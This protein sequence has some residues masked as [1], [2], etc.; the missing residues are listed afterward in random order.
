MEY[1]VYINQFIGFNQLRSTAYAVWQHMRSSHEPTADRVRSPS[2]SLVCGQ[3]EIMML[4]VMG[5]KIAMGNVRSANSYS[6]HLRN[7]QIET[8]LQSRL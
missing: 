1:M 7:K 6:T 4:G 8:S 5:L 3:L 2:H